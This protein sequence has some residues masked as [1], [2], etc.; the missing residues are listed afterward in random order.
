MG[1]AMERISDRVKQMAQSAAIAVDQKVRELSAAG[2]DIVGLGSGEPDF[3]T[4]DNIKQ[5]AIEAIWAGKT[6]YTSVDGIAELKS[7][8]VQKFERENGLSFKPSQ[9]SVGAGGKQIITNAFAA[10]L[11]PGDQV[12]IPAPYWVTYPDSAKVWGGEPVVVDCPQSQGFKMFPGQLDGAITERTGWVI[13]NSPS[14]PSGATYDAGELRAL[15][16]VL[17]KHPHVNIMTDDIYEHIIFDGRPFTTIANVAPELADRILIVNGVSKT[18][19]MTGWRIGYGAGSEEIIRAMAK[20][21]GQTTTHPASISQ[22]ASVEA[23]NGDQQFIGNHV[24]AYQRRRDFVVAEL[25][26]AQG[27]DC[28]VPEGAFYV[29]PSCAGA[30]GK[31]APNGSTIGTDEDFAL[32]LL[33]SEGVAIVHGAAFGLS[34]H[35]RITTAAADEKLAE[36]CKRIKRFCAALT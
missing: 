30:I 24:A 20:M 33:E 16:D 34:P 9:I 7:A 19:C 18:Y 12:I 6:K 11:N 32:A 26:A 25:N 35:F 28:L 3:D 10:T 36:A 13:I 4:P 14:N 15:A 8:I 27:I 5:A 17:L 22:Y 29:Y 1:I 23:L 2:R 31:T 21:Q